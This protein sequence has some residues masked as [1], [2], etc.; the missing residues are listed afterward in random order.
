MQITG[1]FEGGGDGDL[2]SLLEFM[3]AFSFGLLLQG[4]MQ[5]FSHFRCLAHASRAQLTGTII[6]SLDEFQVT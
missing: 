1:F 5:L 3:F 4:V 6:Y 2:N